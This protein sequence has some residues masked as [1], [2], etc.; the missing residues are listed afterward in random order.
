MKNLIEEI[1]ELEVYECEYERNPIGIVYLKD[2]YLKEDLDNLLKQYNII[3]AP[4]RIKLS[5]ILGN[6]KLQIEEPEN[7]IKIQ[8]NREI[9]CI[10][11]G[12]YGED[13][14]QNTWKTL[15]SFYKDL[16]IKNIC[17]KLQDNIKWLYAL[18]IAG[19]EIIDDLEEE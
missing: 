13:W 8:F 5:E 10:G 15:V 12:E 2:C 1:K 17:I 14:Q 3:A 6:L 16:T 9:N 7:L 11:Y 18:W 19:S 4:K